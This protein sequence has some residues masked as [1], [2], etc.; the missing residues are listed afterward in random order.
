MAPRVSVRTLVLLHVS[1]GIPLGASFF[2]ANWPVSIRATLALVAIVVGIAAAS[3]LVSDYLRLNVPKWRA[4]RRRNRRHQSRCRRKR[5]MRRRNGG[6]R[7]NWARRRG[8]R[9]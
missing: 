3:Y 1:N 6:R 5:K 7:A 2:M 4:R 9:R 8:R